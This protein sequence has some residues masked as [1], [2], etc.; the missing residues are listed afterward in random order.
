MRFERRGG[1]AQ[2]ERAAQRPHGA[3]QPSPPRH[4]SYAFFVMVP[5]APHFGHAFGLQRPCFVQPHLS[6]LN[7]AIIAHLPPAVS[8]YACAMPPRSS[9]R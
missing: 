7:S 2:V 6:H 8:R 4:A 9:R 5:A 1:Q 3:A